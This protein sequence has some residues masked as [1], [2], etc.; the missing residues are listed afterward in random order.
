MHHILQ[1][2]LPAIHTGRYLSGHV[3]THAALALPGY[4]TPD[5]LGDS[6][7]ARAASTGAP[8][9][10]IGRLSGQNWIHCIEN[11]LKHNIFV[12]M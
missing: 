12:I 4:I 1:G 7:S 10:D 6:A 9:T 2:S 3:A 8:D 5:T 11:I